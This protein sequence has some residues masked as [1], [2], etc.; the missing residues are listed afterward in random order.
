MIIQAKATANVT[1]RVQQGFSLPPQKQALLCVPASI[2]T[3]SELLSSVQPN[4][5]GKSFHWSFSLTQ[6]KQSFGYS[7]GN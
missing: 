1:A 5:E 3:L 4:W 2:E 6:K 7:T